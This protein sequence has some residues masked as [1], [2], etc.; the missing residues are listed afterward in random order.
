MLCLVCGDPSGGSK[1]GL[2]GMVEAATRHE[3]CSDEDTTAEAEAE[4]RKMAEDFVTMLKRA[5]MKRK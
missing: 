1:P 5:R 3:P 4:L 2:P